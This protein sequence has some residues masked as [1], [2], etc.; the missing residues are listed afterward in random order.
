M[1]HVSRVPHRYHVSVAFIR[2]QVAA[3][4][5]TEVRLPLKRTRMHRRLKPTALRF[6]YGGFFQ[7]YRTLEWRDGVLTYVESRSAEGDEPKAR[8]APT[9]AEWGAFAARLDALHVHRWTQD[10]VDPDVLDGEQWT[11]AIDWPDGRSVRS[12]GSNAYPEA[13]EAVVQAV[14]E[15]TGIDFEA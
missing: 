3:V 10:Y 5:F 11:L 15:L 1:T 4:N 8:L 9:D 6:A 13:F 2:L 14:S 12:T 7:G